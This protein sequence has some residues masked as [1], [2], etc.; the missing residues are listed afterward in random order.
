MRGN[1]DT[2]AL[3]PSRDVRAV[4]GQKNEFSRLRP[5]KKQRGLELSTSSVDYVEL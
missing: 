2:A 4:A 3:L 5:Q 1:A